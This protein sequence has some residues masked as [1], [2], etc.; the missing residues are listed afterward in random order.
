MDIDSKI[1]EFVN[2]IDNIDHVKLA[3]HRLSKRKSDLTPDTRFRITLVL[4]GKYESVFDKSVEFAYNSKFIKK[5]TRWAFTKFALFNVI[6]TICNQLVSGELENL[7]SNLDQV[8]QS[9][10]SNYD[11]YD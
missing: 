1:D 4:P 5:K 10:K 6:D 3:R 11:T 8:P 7:S 2:T 9:D